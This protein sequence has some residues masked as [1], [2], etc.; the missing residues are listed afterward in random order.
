MRQKLIKTLENIGIQ[1]S[2]P[3]KR[4]KGKLY[5]SPKDFIVNEIHGQQICSIDKK[6]TRIHYPI[7]RPYIH[8][9]LVK[10]NISTFEACKTFS[11]VN[12][13]DY[14]KDI[15]VCGL[16]DT[17][18][19]TSQKICIRNYKKI[20][21]V[22]FENFFLKEFQGASKRLDVGSHT[23]NNFIITIRDIQ[24]DGEDINTHF[25]N[26][27]LGLPNFYWFQRFGIR[28]NNHYL[29]KLLILKKYDEFIAHF[30]LDSKNEDGKIKN[31]RKILSENFGD[32][33]KCFKILK[34][35][36]LTDEK[37]LITNLLKFTSLEKA[38]QQMKLSHFFIHAYVSYIFNK[39]L[40]KFIIENG[41]RQVLIEKIGKNTILDK[42]NKQIYK[43][44]LEDEELTLDDI[45][46]SSFADNGHLRYSFFKPKNLCFYEK[47]KNLIIKFDLGKGEYASLVLEFLIDSDK[48]KWC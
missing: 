48:I 41:Y 7:N 47:A 23:G 36:D 45:K 15:F 10:K 16:K 32:W 44:I 9:T 20:K 6:N 27:K 8:A 28:Q 3:K 37:E 29:G 22:I 24:L 14:F 42:F 31:I 38:I 5:E 35:T 30:L 1:I 21:Q 25:E 12:E 18:G 46:N 19:F 13:L 2:L 43:N 39:A 26:F 11:N 34:D 40:S 4:I 33:G 17:L